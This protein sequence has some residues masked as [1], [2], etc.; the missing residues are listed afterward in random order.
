MNNNVILVVSLRKRPSSKQACEVVDDKYQSEWTN[1]QL[2]F[3]LD[4]FH[5]LQLLK[6]MF[7]LKVPVAA[8]LDD[9]C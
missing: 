1:S 7:Q 2:Q 9:S 6:H 5:K 3:Q 8:S 4:S